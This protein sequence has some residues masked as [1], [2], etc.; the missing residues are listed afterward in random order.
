MMRDLHFVEVTIADGNL[1]AIHSFGGRTVAATKTVTGVLLMMMM[2]I[3]ITDEFYNSRGSFEIFLE[4][5]P[6]H[7]FKCFF[8]L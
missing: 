7:L 8:P 3:I 6:R 4:T 1:M 2:V 5:P